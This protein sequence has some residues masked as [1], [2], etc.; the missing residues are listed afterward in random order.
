MGLFSVFR[1]PM[2]VM[3][4]GAMLHDVTASA[5]R[6]CDFSIAP[7]L[8]KAYFSD[9]SSDEM[10]VAEL[11]DSAMH[12]QYEQALNSASEAFWKMGR[13]QP[14]WT[15]RRVVSLMISR[16]ILEMNDRE[17]QTERKSMEI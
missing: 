13:L 11:M 6:L 8:A 12:R 17:P 7:S 2:W 1:C 4:V 16:G 15:A 3:I 10:G 9:P 14:S 5:L